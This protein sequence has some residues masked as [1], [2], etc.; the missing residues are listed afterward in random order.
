VQLDL[1]VDDDLLLLDVHD[2]LL[3]HV[4]GVDSFVAS[5]DAIVDD[6]C[7]G[8]DDYHPNRMRNMNLL[9]YLMTHST[10]NELLVVAM[11]DVCSSV[12]C[13]YDISLDLEVVIVVGHRDF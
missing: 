7:C 13:P 12:H 3:L 1:V 5:F 2:D 8:D 11:E 9:N 4:D 10:V 6:Y